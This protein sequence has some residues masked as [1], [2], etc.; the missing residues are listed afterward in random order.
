LKFNKPELIITPD[1][2]KAKSLGVSVADIAQTLQLSLSGSRFGYFNREGKQYQVIGQFDRE[3]R[4]EPLNLSSIYVRNNQ[5]ELIQLDNLVQVKESVS[6]P[7]LYH[8]NRYKSATVSAG[9]APGKT[10]GDGIDAMDKIAAKVLEP[11]FTTA[12]NGPSRDFAESSSNIMFALGLALVLIYLI[13]SAQFESFLDPLIIMFTVPLAFAGAFLTLWMFGHTWNIFSQIGMIILIGLV[14]KNGILIVEF[15]NH[16]REEGLPL[17]EAVREAS[18]ARLRPILMTS[19]ATIL[20]AVPIAFALGA[21][22]TS[23]IP[24]GLVIIGGLLFSLILTLYVIP[25]IY[26]FISR[27]GNKKQKEKEIPEEH[28]TEYVLV[29]KSNQQV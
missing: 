18:A 7:Q 8:F 3:N 28:T 26:T 13:L 27:T 9:L 6:P 11:G 25:A 16:K 10:I 2:E 29:E 22:A 12:L 17:M 5:G 24:L 15:A 19:L 4:D 23:R 21:G 14:T 20:G 1:R